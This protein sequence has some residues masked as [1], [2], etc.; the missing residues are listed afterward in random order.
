MSEIKAPKQVKTAL[1]LLQNSGFEA[2]AVGGCVR[3]SLLGHAP[4]DWDITT[5][6]RP[7]ETEAVFQAYRLI[8]TGLQH[9]TVTVILDGMPLEITTFR[10]DG[11]YLDAR[12]PESVAF[13]RSLRD[14]L[15]RRDF[16]VNT[17]CWNEKDGIVDL[18]GGIA[19]LQN[20]SCARSVNPTSGFRKTPCGF[21]AGYGLQL[22]SA[23][24]WKRKP[25]TAF[26]VTAGFYPP[27]LKS[28]SVQNSENS[29]ADKMPH[30]L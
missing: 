15:A 3:D 1:H 13:T 29:S 28:A 30:R 5:S 25:P 10:V 22:Y 7:E 16:T 26:C 21:C 27:L 17:L 4:D 6:A 2:Y 20:K 14:D 9:G 8:E 24:H 18:F 19:D 12:H 23:L 11:A